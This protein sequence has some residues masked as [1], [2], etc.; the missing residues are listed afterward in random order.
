MG[1]KKEAIKVISITNEKRRRIAERSG[2]GYRDN[3]TVEEDV[4]HILFLKDNE[5]YTK[6]LSG[7]WSID[8]V[9]KWEELNQWEK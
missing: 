7:S 4:T 9:K 6:T 1:K 2:P 3:E 5:L 8:E